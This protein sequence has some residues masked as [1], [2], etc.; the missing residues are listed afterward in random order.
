MTRGRALVTLV[1]FLV[2][3]A[4]LSA[5][6]ISGTWT[7]EFDSDI[8]KQRYRYVF[9][10]KGTTL[11]GTAT[12]SAVGEAAIE[13]GKVDGNTITFTERGRFQGG[14]FRIDY[15]GRITSADEIKF[16]RKV[17]GLVSTTEQ[18]VARRVKQ[19]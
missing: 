17:V 16:T 14:D 4:R 3:L 8:G 11:T 2:A 6:D 19:P 12:G 9:V 15:T 10:L 13:D 18:I 5:A 1:F 7:A